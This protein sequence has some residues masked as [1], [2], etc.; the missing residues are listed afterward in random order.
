MRFVW[1]QEKVVIMVQ[2]VSLAEF[3]RNGKLEFWEEATQP[4]PTTVPEEEWIVALGRLYENRFGSVKKHPFLPLA[5]IRRFQLQRLK[6]LVAHAYETVPF[7]HR[8]YREKGFHPD[9]L[10]TLDDFR[11]VPIVRKEDLQSAGEDALSSRFKEG[12]LF[13]TKSSGSSGKVLRI[14]VN[15]EAILS[16]TLQGARQFWLQSSSKYSED[17]LLTH[18]YTVPWWFDSILGRYNTAFISSLVRPEKS[19]TLLRMLRSH[20][21]SLYPT[22]LENLISHLDSASLERTYLTVVHS[23]ISTKAQRKTWGEKLGLPVLDEY[24]SEELTRIALELPCGHYHVHEDSVFAEAVDNSGEPVSPG[25]SGLFVGTNLLN[26]AMPFIRYVQGDNILKEDED[27]ECEIGWS[28]LGPIQGR[29]NDGFITKQGTLVPAGTLLDLTYRWMFDSG[30]AVSGFELVQK[31]LDRVDVN[32]W[33]MLDEESVRKLSSFIDAYVRVLLGKDCQVHVTAMDGPPLRS[34][35][36]RPIR[37][38]F[39]L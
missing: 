25:E 16:D 1:R 13:K 11:K 6:Q 34:G 10:S 39:K 31:A 27:S 30:I 19:A 32:F 4:P 24:S 35:K 8:L 5:E 9:Q 14:S 3:G 26:E 7:Y 36:F 37:R 20:V 23:E 12:Y 29:E 21:I 15:L 28:R 33:P 2:E 38:E 18:I 22:N 17:H